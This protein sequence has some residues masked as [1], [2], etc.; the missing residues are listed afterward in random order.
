MPITMT[1]RGE[2]RLMIM[3][4][5]TNRQKTALPELAFASM[6]CFAIC[7]VANTTAIDNPS[8]GHKA[9]KSTASHRLYRAPARAQP[10]L[11]SLV[12]CIWCPALYAARPPPHHKDKRAACCPQPS[13][14]MH[15]SVKLWP[16]VAPLLATA[17][18]VCSMAVLRAPTSSLGMA[19]VSW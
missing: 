1:S 14:R 3:A 13:K 15:S 11:T 12:M 9:L 17:A 8:L 6:S 19:T 16:N 7:V 4:V 2:A 10:M 18:F 5:A